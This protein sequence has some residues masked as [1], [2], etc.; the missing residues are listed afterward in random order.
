MSVLL[1]IAMGAGAWAGG[2]RGYAVFAFLLMAGLAV[3]LVAA[4]RFSE[5]V[6]GLLDRRDERIAS[7]DRD[8]TLASGAV[9][10]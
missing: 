10:P 5:T 9:G 7:L 1:G 2:Q 4:A 3:A 8:A 6:N